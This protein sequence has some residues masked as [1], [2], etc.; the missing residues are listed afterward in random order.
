[1]NQLISDQR[2]FVHP[3]QDSL[4]FISG[5]TKETGSGQNHGHVW[6]HRERLQWWD[7]PVLKPFDL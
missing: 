1:M 4:H 6:R 7:E 3:S 2:T 5:V